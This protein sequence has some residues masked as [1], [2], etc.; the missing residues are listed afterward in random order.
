MDDEAVKRRRDRLLEPPQLTVLDDGA[1]DPAE[2]DARDSFDL[3][4]RIGPIYDVV[5]HPK[6]ET[7]MA[8]AI[9]GDWG[10]ARPP[11]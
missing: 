7:P 1:L 8:M 5:R 2:A 11:P 10:R 6:T 4:F 9:Y 3:A